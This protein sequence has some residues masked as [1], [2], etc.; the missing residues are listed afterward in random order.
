MKLS[1]RVS[2][3]RMIELFLTRRTV[4]LK[5]FYSVL[6][7]GL[8]LV[9]HAAA[10]DSGYFDFKLINR[11]QEGA[12]LAPAWAGLLHH[13]YVSTYDECKDECAT[14]FL[15]AKIKLGK[16]GIYN[17]L[18]KGVGCDCII[19]MSSLELRTNGDLCSNTE[20]YTMSEKV[21]CGN[22]VLDAEE[23][24]DL[25]S[26]LNNGEF[27]CLNTCKKMEGWQCTTTL[28]QWVEKRSMAFSLYDSLVNRQA[29]FDNDGCVQY[30]VNDAVKEDRCSL[31]QED[32]R[33]FKELNASIPVSCG[34]VTQFKQRPFTLQGVQPAPYTIN[35]I[36][37]HSGV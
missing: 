15:D 7:Y 34:G 24:C 27:G 6:L 22:G 33:Q 3:S 28:P 26:T 37:S 16:V 32:L 9:V 4:I 31:Y 12:C 20:V 17:E 10:G 30:Y 8:T 21:L 35:C 5:R 36:P 13:T 23:E 29:T 14:K 18:N 1:E 19:N 11:W 2:R 25:G